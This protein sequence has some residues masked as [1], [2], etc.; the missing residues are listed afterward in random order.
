M[1]ELHVKNN[2]DNTSNINPPTFPD[3]LD[4][5]IFNF[6]SL[7]DTHYNAKLEFEREYVTPF[8]RN[9]KN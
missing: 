7:E 5:E 8:I 6:E 1:V 9:N 4:T 3:G 2:Y